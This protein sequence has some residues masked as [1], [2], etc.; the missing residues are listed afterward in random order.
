MSNSTPSVPSP[1]SRGHGSNAR[2]RWT[3]R[4]G[5]WLGIDV[6]VHAT[7]LG[8]LAFF[9]LSTGLGQ[10]L[11]A[12]QE[13]AGTALGPQT[14]VAPTPPEVLQSPPW[15]RL[16][17]DGHIGIHR[18]HGVLEIRLDGHND[19]LR[20]LDLRAH[21]RRVH[22]S[23]RH[24]L[25]ELTHDHH[26]AH[27]TVLHHGKIGMVGECRCPVAHLVGQRHPQLCAVQGPFTD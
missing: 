18:K 13:H 11:A 22:S 6:Y 26:C 21:Q 23:R 19:I 12:Q 25:R 14:H 3:Y 15:N 2:G 24:R 7:F 17:C 10:G 27:T 5:R 8:L 4:L 9:G 1:S 20:H 16:T